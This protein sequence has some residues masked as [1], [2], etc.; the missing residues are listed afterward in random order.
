[1]LDKSAPL[2]HSAPTTLLY[3]AF[4]LIFVRLNL[5]ISFSELY[6]CSIDQQKV[7]IKGNN[8]N[9]DENQEKARYILYTYDTTTTK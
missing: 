1:M 6:R 8:N 2:S 7:R 5:N 3:I 4:L 9:N